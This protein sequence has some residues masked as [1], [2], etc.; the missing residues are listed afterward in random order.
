MVTN[1]LTRVSYAGYIESPKWGVSLRPG[2]HE[3]LISFETYQNIQKRLKGNAK[4]PAR[5][6]INQDFPLRSFITCGHCGTPLTACWSK[7]RGGHYPYYLCPKKGCQSYRKSIRKEKLEGDFEDLLRRM[8]PTKKLFGLAQVM[9][10]DLW[11]HRAELQKERS[12]S[13][14]L[15]IHKADR[16]IEQFL[17]RIVD[18]KSSSVINAYEKRIQKLEM[19]KALFK[20]K[21]EKCGRPVRDFD[22]TVR[23]ALDFLASPC[24]LWKSDRLEDK[25]AVLKLA[26]AD[27]LSYLKNEGVRTVKTTLP[28]KVLGEISSPKSEVVRPEGF[29]PPTPWFEAKY[30]IQL[31]YGRYFMEDWCKTYRM[32]IF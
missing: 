18:A 20:E 15:E 29:E 28:F 3:G 30:S 32:L 25:H 10:E 8:A 27:R 23:T 16:S 9:F 6:D 31:S 21:I 14:E 2:Q 4:T 24:N 1:L 22:V 5:K 7:G 13:M 11:N 19:D 26:F 12:K 17:D